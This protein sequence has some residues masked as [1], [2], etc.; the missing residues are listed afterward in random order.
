[1][2][3]EIFATLVGGN[4]DRQQFKIGSLGDDKQ[5]IIMMAFG[6]NLVRLV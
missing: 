3:S 2:K 1:M 5:A 4:T 6:K